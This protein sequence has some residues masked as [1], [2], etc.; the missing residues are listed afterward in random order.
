MPNPIPAGFHSV[1]PYLL[2]SDVSKLMEFLTA[3]LGATERYKMPGPNGGV[4][5]AEMQLGDSII[6]MGRPQSEEDYRRAM[7][8]LY[9]PDVDATYRG[10]SAAGATSLQELKNEFYGDRRGAVRDPLGNDWLSPRTVEDV[11][12]KEMNR[13]MA[14][15]RAGA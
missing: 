6:M 7:L 13:R 3:A 2:V 14:A 4:M 9:V 11:S 1:T 10:A 12:P 5:H 15:Q 8:Y